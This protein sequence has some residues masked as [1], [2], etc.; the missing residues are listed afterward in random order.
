MIGAPLIRTIVKEMA[1]RIKNDYDGRRPVM[2]CTLKGACSFFIHL[3][4]ELQELR[5]GYDVEFARA[6][7]YHGTSTTGIVKILGELNVDALHGR[8]VLIVED[9]VDTGTTLSNLVPMLKELGKPSSVEVVTLL[10]K[11]LDDS[12]AKKFNAKYVG[13]SVPNHFIIGYG[14][15]LF[16]FLFFFSSKIPL[17]DPH[18]L[19]LLFA[20]NLQLGLQ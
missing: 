11:R 13:F 19:K 18:F 1:A 3:L 2:V 12:N 10:D 20:F 14:Y 7:S 4:D 17:F 16:S 6:Q 9:I 15:V 5:F 8:Q